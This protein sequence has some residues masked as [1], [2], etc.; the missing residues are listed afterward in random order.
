MQQVKYDPADVL[1]AVSRQES[2]E[3]SASPAAAKLARSASFERSTSFEWSRELRR[4]HQPSHQHPSSY[5]HPPAYRGASSRQREA[6]SDATMQAINTAMGGTALAGDARSSTDARST[7]AESDS[8]CEPR[9]SRTPSSPSS[10]R[11]RAP[12]PSPRVPPAATR[13]RKGTPLVAHVVWTAG[14]RFAMTGDNQ[15]PCLL[16]WRR[17]EAHGEA[18]N[19]R[20]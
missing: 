19:R 14:G 3:R 12:S 9:R 16:L 17:G 2:H 15:Q 11:A 13:R 6:L 5:Q 10:L 1:R 8:T 4:H 20:G 7:R 18:A